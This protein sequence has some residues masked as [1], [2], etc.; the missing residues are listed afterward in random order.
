MPPLFG[1]NGSLGGVPGDVTTPVVQDD[2]A[3]HIHG[4]VAGAAIWT[5]EFAAFE[6]KNGSSD[7]TTPAVAWRPAAVT[8]GSEFD[9][10]CSSGVVHIGAELSELEH[11][12]SLQLTA[13]GC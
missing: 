9:V 1:C 10:S 2:G 6:T 3:A 7:A 4:T 13:C 12:F 11:G 5:P 8:S